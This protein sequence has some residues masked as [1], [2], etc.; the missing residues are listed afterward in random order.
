M[1]F[2][3]C[4]RSASPPW[5][6]KILEVANPVSFSLMLIPAFRAGGEDFARLWV[7]VFICALLSVVCLGSLVFGRPF[8]SDFIT[9][10]ADARLAKPIAAMVV[11]LTLTLGIIFVFM[12]GCN[13]VVA[14]RGFEFGTSYVL[15]NFAIP[16]G[17]LALG[18]LCVMPSVG[19]KAFV[20]VAL[21]EHGPDWERA[22]FPT[23][24]SAR[25]GAAN[26][27]ST[28]EYIGS[29]GIARRRGDDSPA[30]CH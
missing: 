15:W 21:A 25:E 9:A 8:L 30:L 14:I 1:L 2:F 7:G 11:S 27:V 13:L 20:N 4:F 17:S 12:L 5:K 3:V 23:E 18:V 26:A 16:F 22:L 19:K 28:E 24:V 10:P 6:P 29:D